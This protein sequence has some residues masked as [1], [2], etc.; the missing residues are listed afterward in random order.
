MKL[1]G[2]AVNS[3]INS[4]VLCKIISRDIMIGTWKMIKVL[5][6]QD[7]YYIPQNKLKI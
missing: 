4:A 1:F 2:E 3:N 7:E 5:I 6:G